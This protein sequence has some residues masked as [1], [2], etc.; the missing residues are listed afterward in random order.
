MRRHSC[1]V[2]QGGVGVE[3]DAHRDVTQKF[4]EATLGTEAFHELTILDQGV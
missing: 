1:K 2:L 4:G 3:G